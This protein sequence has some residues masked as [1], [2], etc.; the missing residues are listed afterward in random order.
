[1]H[2]QFILSFLKKVLLFF[3]VF[4]LILNNAV[5]YA[6]PLS[7]QTDY[8]LP[9]CEEIDEVQLRVELTRVIQEFLDN[10]T[11]VNFQETVSRQWRT[12]SLD[13]VF[14]D[15]IDNAVLAVNSNT[16]SMNRFKSSWMP[17]KA[18]EL[19]NQVTQ[20]AFNSSSLKVKLNQ[21]SKNVAGGL[22]DKLEVASAKS[23]SYA[24]DC[25]QQF[26]N[27]QY[28]QTFVDVFSQKI[29]DSVEIDSDGIDSLS[30]N[31]IQYINKHKFGLAGS[32][33]L[34]AT[35][36]A[37]IKKK[38]VS[39]IVDRVF[40]QVGERVL[41]RLGTGLI[42]FLGE[43]IGIAL[44]GSDLIK[45]FDG[46]LPEIQKSLKA[47]E[48]KQKIQKEIAN[49]VEKEIRNE[50]SQIAREVSVEIYAQWLEFRT[51]YT[52]VL[53]L[54]K[55]LPEF[56]EILSKT[57]NL[58]QISLL[59]GVALNN[60]GRSQLVASIEDGTFERVLS[61][62]EVSYKILETT[63]NLPSLVAWTN[64]AGNL[65]EEVVKL[66]LYKNLSPEDLDHQLLVEI[67]ALKAPSTISKI[68]LL[69]IS[70]I[71]RLLSISK[72]NLVA[73]SQ[74][75]SPEDL[76]QLAGYLGQLKQPQIN[77][78]VKFLL[79]DDGSSFENADVMAHIVQSRKIDSAIEFW[80]AQKNSSLLLDGMLKIFTGAISWRLVADK[81]NMPITL[82]F[83]TAPIVLLLSLF[84]LIGGWIY[85]QSVKIEKPQES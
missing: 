43:F 53:N 70:S 33:L 82:F 72:Q 38:V 4:C 84:S 49:Q 48:V 85:R 74:H 69:D 15:E 60:M 32:A 58:S 55:E 52:E 81:F 2:Y 61:F 64:L 54:A 25:L 76:Q 5:V 67:L 57:T 29:K 65:I 27:R 47:P 18:E 24:I 79:T 16:D 44:I 71:R 80:E 7:E 37:K 39:T 63:H 51:D 42:P 45:S 30:P 19:A 41:G 9:K 10:Q 12:L 46:A 22:V 59:V 68:S 28:S 26:V 73:L 31:T 23:S 6:A 36:T 21:L 75:L 13:S 50:T 14:D 17:S 56:K 83:T 20:I 35:I 3:L 66:E 40:Q 77:Q 78:F 62:P 1:M 34:V 8:L 11:N